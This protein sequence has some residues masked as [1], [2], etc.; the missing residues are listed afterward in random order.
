MCFACAS[1]RFE[2]LPEPRCPVCEQRLPA[3]GGCVNYW[4]RHE[5]E[6]EFDTVWAIAMRSGDL[7][8]AINRYKFQDKTGWASI[9]GRVLVG[10]LDEHENTFSGYDLI[11]ASPTYLGPGGR[12]SWDH[13]GLVLDR[14]ARESSRWPFDKAHP[15]GVVKTAETPSMIGKS[16]SERRQ[17][18]EELLRPNLSVTRDVADARILVFDDVFTAGNTLREVAGVLKRAGAVEVS[19]IVLAR[20]PWAY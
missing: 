7:E 5:G 17:I 6:R 20:Q 18:A 11:I 8:S 12:R 10:F 15:R 1:Q 4:C 3:T 9:F 19:Q 13:I 14:A 2:S 16:L